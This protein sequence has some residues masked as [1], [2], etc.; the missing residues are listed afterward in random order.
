MSQRRFVILDRDGT[1]IIERNYLSHP[2]EVELLPG[3]GQ[4]L[5]ELRKLDL[6]L[7]VVT[8]QSGLG[9]GYLDQ[10]RLDEIHARLRELLEA[11]SAE[12]DGIYYCPHHPDDDCSCRKPRP[13]LVEL[14]ARELHFDP[15]A[16]FFIGD[17]ACD[18]DLGRRLGGVTFLVRTCY[19]RQ[20]EASGNVEP[21]F[22]VD[23][24][25]AAVKIIK[26]ALDGG[27]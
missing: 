16:S 20:H 27:R 22:M 4:A 13:G 11:E 10:A 7:V 23:D 21:H 26:N 14:A 9:R 17:K 12:P 3:V 18:V 24:L 5:R 1:I 6:G 15:S 25:V 2:D 19:G 8:N